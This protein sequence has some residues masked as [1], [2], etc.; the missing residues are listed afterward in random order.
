MS[1]LIKNAKSDAK[2]STQRRENEE[3]DEMR[4]RSESMKQIL[5]ILTA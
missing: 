5:W 4:T 2:M 1:I 3:K